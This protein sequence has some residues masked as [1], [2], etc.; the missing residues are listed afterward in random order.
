MPNRVGIA[1]LPLAPKWRDMTIKRT[2]RATDWREIDRWE[3]GT[4][5]IA[6]PDEA[7]QRA[8]HALATGE[9][10]VWVIDPVD[11]EGLDDLLADLGDVA[12]VA[13]LLDR[14]TRDADAIA[15]RYDVPVS[16]PEWMTGVAEKVDAP[17]N[18]FDHSLP[19]TG[20]GVYKLVDNR[21]WQEA[22]LYDPISRT[23]VVPEAVGTNDFSVTG[24]ERV[25]VQA[26]LRLTPPRKLGQLSPDRLLV[27]H[28]DGIMENADRALTDALEGSRRRAPG[29]YAESLREFVL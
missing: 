17:L 10:D 20:Y 4:G 16:V 2:G 6:H 29:L 18:R 23:M 21:F 5:W 13:V 19:G 7:M 28:G 15:R 27:G 24:R 3:G 14:H 12:G 8:S 11:V 25:G 22:M 9:D 1:L 26:A